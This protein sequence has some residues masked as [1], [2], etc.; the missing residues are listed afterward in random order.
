M[1]RVPFLVLLT[2]LAACTGPDLQTISPP[3]LKA[4]EVDA[5]SDGIRLAAAWYGERQGRSRV[6]VQP[7]TA[8]GKATVAPF[9][10]T[11]G[12]REAFEPDLQ[13]LG[14]DYLVAW[15]EKPVQGGAA[16][17]WI[18]LLDDRGG[19][20]W[21]RVLPAESGSGLRP[22]VRVLGMTIH[23]AWI[24]TL[25][26]DT[27]DLW[28][29]AYDADGAEVS[30][31]RAVAA[32]NADTWNLNAAVDNAG[33]MHVVYDARLG[34][35]AKELQQ[36]VI[37][38][39]TATMQALTPDDGHD[40]LYPDI[41]LSGD[42]VALTWFDTRD[43]NEEVYLASGTLVDSLVE[44]VAKARRVTDTAGHSIGAYVAWNGQRLGLAWTDDTRG[45]ADA[46]YQV[47][48]AAL[49]PEGAARP[50][51]QTRDTASIPSI[52]PAGPGFAIAWNEYAQDPVA[53]AHGGIRTSKA[54]LARVR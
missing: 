26:D 53:A 15:Y 3:A 20:R 37:D 46:Y 4:Y 33:R 18:A 13:F 29:A 19:E 1:I 43:G 51:L 30:A 31:P 32:A 5:A 14:D 22:V 25:G 9:A 2:A 52:V 48:D 35:R 6:Y 41:A 16:S 21:R 39:D 38:G 42:R 40:S 27:A 47:F 23:V 49:V 34:T 10:V 8:R 7:L 54:M 12:E 28:Y 24:R 44:R 50:L 36:V 17:A 11:D 45:R